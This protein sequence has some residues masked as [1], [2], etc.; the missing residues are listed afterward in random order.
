MGDAPNTVASFEDAKAALT[1]LRAG[2]RNADGTFAP[3]HYVSLKTGAH[4]DR[5]LE[6]PAE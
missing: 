6:E 2:G 1:Q 4:S 3:G 5:L